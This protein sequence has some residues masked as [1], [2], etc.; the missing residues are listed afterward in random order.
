MISVQ[1]KQEATDHPYKSLTVTGVEARRKCIDSN[2]PFVPVANN[3]ARQ[4]NCALER[5]RPKPLTDSNF[6]FEMDFL[7]CPE[8]FVADVYCGTARHRVFATH[9]QLELLSTCKRR[10][11]DATF[12]VL[13]DPFASG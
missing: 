9:K 3:F 11:L 5:I 10:F 8:F 4:A 1:V 6:E 2:H 13:G 12:S 7:K